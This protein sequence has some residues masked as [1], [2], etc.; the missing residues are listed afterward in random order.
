MNVSRASRAIALTLVVGL[1]ATAC[2]GGPSAEVSAFCEDY[3][4]VDNLMASGPDEADPTPWV[5]GMT[6]GLEGLKADA[7]SEVSGAVERMADSL[8]EPIANLDE[9]GFFAATESDAFVEDAAV[10]DDY[11]GGECGFETVE[12]TA[13]DYAFEA[14]LDSVEAGTVVFDFSNEGTEL[15]EMALIR[16]NDDTTESIEELLEMPEEE[17]DTKATFLGA[18]FAAP[19]SGDAM[20]ADLDAGRY[21]VVCFIPTGSTSMEEVETADGPPHFT[22]GMLREFTVEG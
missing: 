10:V 21:V 14:D 19:G 17:A 1:V 16:I 3:V 11:I 20:Y 5:E 8:L 22:H 9:E 12:V 18:S 6:T 2:N 7:P 13:V 4:A 15:H